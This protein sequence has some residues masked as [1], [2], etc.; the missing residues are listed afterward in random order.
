MSSVVCNQCQKEIEATKYVKCY[1]CKSN[2][3]FSTCCPLSES[4]YSTM[5]GERRV[6]WRCQ[7]CK[8]RNKSP[9][10][11]AVVVDENNL[12]KQQREDDNDDG[13]D[14]AKKFKESL[15]PASLN[16]K[17]TSLENGMEVMKTQMDYLVNNA[18][19]TQQLR[20]EI[21]QALAAMTNTISS[22]SAQVCELNEKDKKKE[23]Q[24][25]KMD[26]RINNIEQQMLVK[27]IEIKNVKNNEISAFEVVKKIAAVKNV[28]IKEEDISNAYR[29]KNRENKIIIEFSSLNKKLELLS[30]I[31]RHRIEAHLINTDGENNSSNKYIYINDQLSYSNR[32]LLW[33]AKTKAKEFR[34]KF[35][36]IRNGKIFVRKSENSP[37]ILINNAA[38]I[39]YITATI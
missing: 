23:K 12:Q 37:S 15:S 10:T 1:N 7:I 17:L 4:T 5:T 9:N 38:D 24:I 30:K 18:N 25:S 13:S 32:Q 3:H 2:Y 16:A 26:I 22:L 35:V 14:R 36:W 28:E 11:Q 8:P 29:I 6:N 34:W 19:A 27:N 39:E 31:E 20:D 21:H 33:I